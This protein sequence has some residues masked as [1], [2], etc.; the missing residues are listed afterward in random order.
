[1]GLFD[2]QVPESGGEHQKKDDASL[3]DNIFNST[4][5]TVKDLPQGLWNL[6]GEVR[7]T[8]GNVAS[9]PGTT[10]ASVLKN[11]LGV[12]PGTAES[13]GHIAGIPFAGVLPLIGHQANTVDKELLD[14]PTS[15]EGGTAW[16][17]YAKKFPFLANTQESGE[18]TAVRLKDQAV[19]TATG[20]FYESPYV[21]AYNEGRLGNVLMEDAANVGLVADIA[22][23]GLTR[24]AQVGNM[25]RA[26]TLAANAGDAAMPGLRG[27]GAAT[28]RTAGP[29]LGPVAPQ[30][31]TV[32]RLSERA[33][34]LGNAVANAPY[35][36]LT[37]PARVPLRWAR[38][39]DLANINAIRA[40]EVDAV[41]AM[42]GNR[43][44]QNVID[45][46]G[47]ASRVGEALQPVGKF[48]N[49]S[50]ARAGFRGGISREDRARVEEMTRPWRDEVIAADQSLMHPDEGIAASY[51]TDQTVN[52]A[53]AHMVQG[54]MDQPVVD[55][56]GAL[57][58]PSPELR[59][60]RAQ[61]LLGE[62]ATAGS[63]DLYVEALHNPTK[64]ARLE[65][66]R[67]AT[68]KPR[69]ISAGAVQ[70]AP[71]AVGERQA[72]VGRMELPDRELVKV[73]A[74]TYPTSAAAEPVL[75]QVGTV[76]RPPRSVAG[77]VP[78]TQTYA[79]LDLSGGVPEMYH[80]SSGELPE[81]P[82]TPQGTNGMQNRYGPGLYTTDTGAI[83]GEYRSKGDAAWD[84]STGNMYRAEWTGERPPQVLDLA[85]PL[86]DEVR[87]Q[88]NYAMNEANAIAGRP[89]SEFFPKGDYPA[90]G[91]YES[92][93]STLSGDV[94]A[95][96]MTAEQADGVLQRLN[97]ERLPAA[98]YDAM[99]HVGGD[100]LGD[101][102][103][104]VLIWLTDGNV[105]LTR[106]PPDQI[107]G[108]TF[109]REVPG[110]SIPLFAE[111]PLAH[112][113]PDRPGP[114]M[115]GGAPAEV[116]TRPQKPIPIFEDRVGPDVPQ[117]QPLNPDLPPEATGKGW[118]QGYGDQRPITDET[119]AIRQSEGLGY[120]PLQSSI[121][122]TLRDPSHALD[123]GWISE[124]EA[125]KINQAN[126]TEEAVNAKIEDNPD[127]VATAAEKRV[128]AQRD[129]IGASLADRPA[130]APAAQRPQLEV[131]RNIYKA[132]QEQA[133]AL[134]EAGHDA[135]ADAIE[136]LTRE[137]QV[138][139]SQVAEQ[140]TLATSELRGG[141]LQQPNGRKVSPKLTSQPASS[142]VRES[143]LTVERELAPQAFRQYQNIQQR[144]H[145]AV[146]DEFAQ[147]N[148]RTGADLARIAGADTFDQAA[149]ARA[150]EQGRLVAYDPNTRM[151]VTEAQ[152]T[153]ET[154]FLPKELTGA[155]ADMG[156]SWAQLT[157][158]NA[159]K[160]LRAY[161]KG[162]QTWKMF[163]LGLSPRWNVGNLVGNAMM[164]ATHPGALRPS[165]LVDAIQTL[166]SPEGLQG[167]AL[168]LSGESFSGAAEMRN[169][170]DKRLGALVEE[171]P[172]SL[173][174]K[175]WGKVK[176]A[177]GVGFG[178]NQFIDDLSHHAVYSAEM[179][180]AKAKNQ[181][182]DRLE[183]QGAISKEWATEMRSRVPTAEDA[184]NSALK[185]AGD[186][187]NLSRA[188]QEV[189]RRIFPF[190]PW[191]K[192]ITQ[193]A[194]KFPLDHPLRAAWA[195]HLADQY[196]DGQNRPDWLRG[197]IRTP[198]GYVR[199]AFNPFPGGVE[200]PMIPVDWETG[201]PSIA[202]MMGGVTPAV[203]TL[204][205]L[206]GYN[207]Y[208][209]EPM[210]RPNGQQGIEWSQYP[211]ILSGL[212]PQTRFLA[213]VA[214]PTYKGSD[215]VRYDTG[216]PRFVGGRPMQS[217]RQEFLGP[218]GAP[219]L[220]FTAGTSVDN[221]NIG[222]VN[223]IAA[224]KEAATDKQRRRYEQQRRRFKV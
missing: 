154:M 104:N 95:G 183:A 140:G 35:A 166:R 111:Q 27:A 189:V 89:P 135:A 12:S 76:T 82:A 163:T 92:L 132:G 213:D 65:E 208:K 60:T 176:Q 143:G 216:D 36:A 139:L 88:F 128:I 6:G 103:H 18:R 116:V 16:Q 193:L 153:P 55:A 130:Y 161:D 206:S 43:P 109:Q 10:V 42:T 195:V 191:Y 174:G 37:A 47:V 13:V 30:L 63:V 217:S 173:V 169:L 5:G 129:K 162:M 179:L 81:G 198:F 144:V 108:A 157:D 205:S 120:G 34:G 113:T 211:Y 58:A 64:M 222:E 160:A 200:S 78:D 41:A 117:Q 44:L 158:S 21:K 187:S 170:A 164:L 31:E 172:T 54:L 62:K 181:A 52:P 142:M 29:L 119:A 190:Y 96:R 4:V 69:I 125:R 77:V 53:N 202:P 221:A 136:Q 118:A 93:K 57:V 79:P 20:D 141:L 134:R 85:K 32:A 50:A 137:A 178:I 3:W 39:A 38:E 122:E 204:A 68:E 25:E 156:K 197:A 72:M 97:L 127:Y 123:Q 80:G 145:N 224:K 73:G 48:L 110:R 171:G 74:E 99:A 186:F 150:A 219:L 209:N 33:G 11:N 114:P 94:R 9:L 67:A 218:L 75:T 112:Y 84:P 199:G 207:T 124:S 2:G 90:T 215:V 126:A 210:S 105:S 40:P 184:M 70:E 98:G 185:V 71:P 192:H 66:L 165:S 100:T 46:T 188:E 194:W 151:P 212:T 147:Q 51:L 49:E 196:G 87:K 182:I 22:G 26:G 138:T 177:A 133:A 102:Q 83:G 86:T 146:I 59:D 149:V 180:G 223:A 61:D 107:P 115:I 101:R 106:V 23:G 19:D 24:A 15:A 45:N 14:T 1:M 175:G 148:A 220:N 152:F 121:D 203:S 214:G 17:M 56:N 155:I 91:A 7:E 159:A 28:E 131:G 8:A 168:R 201:R 167:Q